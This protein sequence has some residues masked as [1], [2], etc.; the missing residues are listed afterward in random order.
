MTASSTRHS[1]ERGI[2]CTFKFRARLK[3]GAAGSATIR[4]ID[5]WARDPDNYPRMKWRARRR[6]QGHTRSGAPR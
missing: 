5:P 1:D 3:P 6:W 2:A 4:L